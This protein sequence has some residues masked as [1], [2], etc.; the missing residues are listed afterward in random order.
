MIDNVHDLADYVLKF[1]NQTHRSV[2]LTGK[3]GTGK[4][5]LLREIMRTTHKNAAVVA[6]TGI[7]ALNAQGVTIHSLFQLPFASFLPDEQFLPET[8]GSV[9]FENRQ[10]IRRHFSMRS[11][12]RDIIRNLELLIV[13]EVSMLRADVLDVIDYM[14]RT[15]RRDNRPFGNVQMLFIGDLLQLPPVVK[16]AEWDVLRN[17]Y[18]SMYFFDAHVIRDNPPLYIELEKIYRQSDPTFIQV[19][20]HLRENYITEEDVHILNQYVK[21]DFDIKKYPGYITLTTHNNNADEMNQQALKELQGREYK[22]RAIID[23]NF[24]DKIYPIDENLVLKKGAQVM[25]IKND[26]NPEKRYYNGKIGHVNSISNSSIYVMLEDGQEIEVERYEWQNVSYTVDENTKEIKEEIL[27]TFTQYPLKLAW[28]ITVHKSQGLTFEK[29]VLDISKVFAP[30]QAYV[31]LSRLTSLEGLVLLKPIQLNGL[32]NDQAVMQYAQQ[33]EDPSQLDS[34][35]ETSTLDYITQSLIACF[36]WTPVHYLWQSHIRTYSSDATKSKKT[37][38]MKW[39]DDMAANFK[40]HMDVAHKFAVQLQKA[41]GEGRIDIDYINERFEKAYEYFFPILSE[42]H[43]SV[44]EVMLKA[45]RMTQMKAFNEEVLELEEAHL[46]LVLDL[47]KNRRLLQIYRENKTIDKANLS[48]E[49][50]RDYRA[51][52]LEKVKLKIEEESG[53]I[54]VDISKKSKAKK[55]APKKSTY[56]ITYELWQEFGDVGAIAEKRSLAPSTISGHLARLVQDGKIAIQDVL[57]YELIEKLSQVYP[58]DKHELPMSEVVREIADSEISYT[59]L[60]M[61]RAHCANEEEE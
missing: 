31:A 36:T 39:A 18:S 54:F 28:A 15:I 21:A 50:A 10:T 58:K 49:L 7:A 33:K 26:L 29:A 25:F 35:L 4:T 55:K 51:Q 47:L 9:R 17:Y 59:E 30:G 13:D 41:F 34:Q 27:G 12:K 43:E 5:T 53:E 60:R 22:Y 61:Y 40:T 48:T 46:K 20:N 52:K 37:Q 16:R 19:L 44:L 38:F 23:G 57:S 32:S 24:P 56:L 11:V 3:A 8:Y 2:F 1:V 6:P 45:Q 42:M 14:L